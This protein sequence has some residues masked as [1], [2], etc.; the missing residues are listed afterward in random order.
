MIHLYD[1]Q[2]KWKL[3]VYT[4][5]ILYVFVAEKHCVFAEVET[6]FQT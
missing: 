1:T 2:I 6:K 5:L 3:F 4:T